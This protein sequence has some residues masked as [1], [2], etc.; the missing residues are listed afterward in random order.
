MTVS[1]DAHPSVS[2]HPVEYH[3]RRDS[4]ECLIQSVI[5]RQIRPL[6]RVF[7]ESQ[8][9][10]GGGAVIASHKCDPPGIFCA[11][12]QGSND[13]LELSDSGVCQSEESRKTEMDQY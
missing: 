6:Y 5:Q 3:A 9:L 2:A 8:V 12:F 4:A 11:A 1:R 10:V 13:L 7:D